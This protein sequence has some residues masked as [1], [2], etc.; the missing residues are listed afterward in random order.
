M[1]FK[2]IFILYIEP[3]IPR[4]IR[5]L[6]CSHG[7]ITAD[8]HP[9]DTLG[10]NEICKVECTNCGK[11]AEVSAGELIFGVWKPERDL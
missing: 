4:I 10:M 2:R 8:P 7:Y 1:L 6:W 5:R 9:S 3:L 11:K